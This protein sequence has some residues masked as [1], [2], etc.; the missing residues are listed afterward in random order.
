MIT[1]DLQDS[2]F[3]QDDR[4]SKEGDSALK[5]RLEFPSDVVDLFDDI[6]SNLGILSTL[7][8]KMVNT[9]LRLL[10]S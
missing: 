4:D 8:P 3:D 7:F 2:E 5:G 6:K 9:T 1:L 10:A